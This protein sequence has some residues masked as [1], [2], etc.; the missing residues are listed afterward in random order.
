MNILLIL[1]PAASLIVLFFIGVFIWNA[2]SGQYDDLDGEAM[3]ILNDNNL[4][5]KN[6]RSKKNERE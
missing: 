3:R 1:I 6:I 4:S 2:H 5:D